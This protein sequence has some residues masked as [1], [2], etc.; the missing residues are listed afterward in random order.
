MLILIPGGWSW[1]GLVPLLTG[2]AGFCPLYRVFGWSTVESPQGGAAA[3][4]TFHAVR[5]RWR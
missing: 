4:G 2:F 1:L 5:R 3:H